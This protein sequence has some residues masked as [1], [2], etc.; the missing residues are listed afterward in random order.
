MYLAAQ[1]MFLRLLSPLWFTQFGW[2]LLRL[3]I[4]KRYS[5]VLLFLYLRIDI[6]YRP[7]DLSYEEKIA[8][9]NGHGLLLR[10]AGNLISPCIAR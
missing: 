5:K 6:L 2:S 4:S 1:I 10:Y 3:D 9:F 8:N 7:L